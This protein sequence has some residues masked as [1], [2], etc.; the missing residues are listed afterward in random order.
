LD[1]R[2]GGLIAKKFG[3]L[4]ES[5]GREVSLEPWSRLRD[6]PYLVHAG[7]ELPLMLEGRKPLAYFVDRTKWLEEY[8][9]PFRRFVDDGR[10]VKR[11]I[12]SET[13]RDVTTVYFALPSEQ[14]RID[15][16][17][18][19]RKRGAA[20]GW[21]AAMEREEGSLLGYSDWENDRWAEWRAVIAS[22]AHS[23][24]RRSR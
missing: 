24:D 23:G 7:F 2:R 19:L 8:L 15:A 13:E 6:L 4:F 12:E 17:V 1:D 14:W 21:N 10:I 11:L 20:S 9:E 5:G 16:H 3:T 18:A 22:S